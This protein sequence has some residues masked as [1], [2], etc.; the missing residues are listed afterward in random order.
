ML[1]SDWLDY[2]VHLPNLD[3]NFLSQQVMF[4]QFRRSVEKLQYSVHYNHGYN[5][6]LGIN[7]P[8]GFK[9]GITNLHVDHSF[10]HMEKAEILILIR[11]THSLG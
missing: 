10:D 6:A 1:A 4:L 2:V 9:V 3:V 11:E 7:I 5:K 8:G